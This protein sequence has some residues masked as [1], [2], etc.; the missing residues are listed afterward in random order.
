MPGKKYKE[1]IKK[2]EAGKNYEPKEALS[3][4]KETSYVNFDATVDEKLYYR[5][6]LVP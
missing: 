2:V 5:I 1:M 4:I 6:R 3:L